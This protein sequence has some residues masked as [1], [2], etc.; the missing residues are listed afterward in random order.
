[1]EHSTIAH[2]EFPFE[3]N[4]EF[5]KVMKIKITLI[6]IIAYK[7]LLKTVI[8]FICK[9]SCSRLLQKSVTSK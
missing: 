4:S 1:M 8:Y 6:K 5:T 2:H 3:V 7:S 9:A